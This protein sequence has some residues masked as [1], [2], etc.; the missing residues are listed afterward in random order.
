MALPRALQAMLGASLAAFPDGARAGAGEGG[1]AVGGGPATTLAVLAG[2][3]IAHAGDSTPLPKRTGKPWDAT[4]RAFGEQHLRAAMRSPAQLL[5]ALR[6]AYEAPLH[7]VLVSGGSYLGLEAAVLPMPRQ[8]VEVPSAGA[9]AAGAPPSP[10]GPQQ[11]Q[12]QE[13]DGFTTPRMEWNHQQSWGQE[14]EAQLGGGGLELTAGA[15]ARLHAGHPGDTPV[16]QV[17]G[18]CR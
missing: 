17:V 11:Q 9:P 13:G 1:C 12:G 18:E 16:M 2:A 6:A 15:A 10:G 5:E 3:F 4:A 7:A 14:E 8:P